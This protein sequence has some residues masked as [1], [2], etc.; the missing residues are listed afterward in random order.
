VRRQG[1]GRKTEPICGMHKDLGA[2]SS[3][4][5]KPKAKGPDDKGN[6]KKRYVYF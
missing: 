6:E 2:A 1:K 5:L 4:K 3:P